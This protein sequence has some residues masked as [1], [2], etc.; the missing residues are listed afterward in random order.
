MGGTV[1]SLPHLSGAKRNGNTAR[2]RRLAPQAAVAVGHGAFVGEPWVPTTFERSGSER[3]PRRSGRR[4]PVCGRRPRGVCGGNRACGEQLLGNPLKTPA[5]KQKRPGKSGV[6]SISFSPT[7]PPHLGRG[8]FVGGTVGSIP[9]LSGAKR[10]GNTRPQA[11]ACTASRCGR[12]PRGVCGGNRRFP[13]TFEWSEAEREFP[14]AG[15]G[16]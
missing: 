16:L 1:G 2:R 11:S 8:A 13:T 7:P 10:N 14:P 12:R 4:K 3:N 15:V 5:E 6:L 9:H